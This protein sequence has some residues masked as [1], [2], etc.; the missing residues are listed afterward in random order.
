[1][2]NT[3]LVLTH[4]KQTKGEQLSCLWLWDV[5]LSNILLCCIFELN[6]DLFMNTGLVGWRALRAYGKILNKRVAVFSAV[7]V[8]HHLVILRI[9]SI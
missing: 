6:S 8:P 9:L 2:K 4:R 5:I 7:G 3:V 1:M